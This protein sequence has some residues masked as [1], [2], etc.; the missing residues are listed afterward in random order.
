MTTSI[1]AKKLWANPAFRK[2]MSLAHK[3]QGVKHGQARRNNTT[4]FYK[5]W[6]NMLN[7]CSCKAYKGYKNYGGKG[8][9]VLWNNFEHFKEDMEKSY[10][11]HIL[12][13]G[14]KDTSID[15]IDNN[16]NYC[17]ENCKWSTRKE[18]AKNQGHF[19]QHFNLGISECLEIL[20]K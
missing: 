20:K 13:Y 9:K 17:K 4:R 2:R 12:Q 8:I 5:T 10:K 7:R 14:E 6:Q 19:N 15:R 1:K 3:N 11:E 18:Q 16:K